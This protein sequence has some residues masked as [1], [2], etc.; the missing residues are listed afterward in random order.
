MATKIDIN[1]IAHLSRLE[2][3]ATQ[4]DMAQ[5]FESVL[6][7]I[8]Q[9]STVDVSGIEPLSHPIEGVHS[10]QDMREDAVTEHDQR[11]KLQKNA[12]ETHSG[13]YIVPQ[14]IE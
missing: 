11:E 9:L 14:V 6:E 2:L 5:K 1:R 4:D 8:D 13:L 12:P 7:F 3:G 10:Q